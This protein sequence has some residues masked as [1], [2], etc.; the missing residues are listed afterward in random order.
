MPYIP[1]ISHPQNL[2]IYHFFHFPAPPLPGSSW[3]PSFD[4]LVISEAR[5]QPQ[6]RQVRLDGFLRVS[7]GLEEP[8]HLGEAVEQRWNWKSCFIRWEISGNPGKNG[9]N[10]VIY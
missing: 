8:L 9:K 10:H 6:R 3:L 1:I 4:D 7:A 5:R 2:Q